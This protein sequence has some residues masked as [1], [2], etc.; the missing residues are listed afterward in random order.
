MTSAHITKR[1]VDAAKDRST[2][3]FIWD[4]KLAGFGLKVTPA[5]RK[6]YLFQYRMH[7][8]GTTRRVT[9]GQHGPWTPTRARDEAKRLAGL[10][11]SGTD[12]AA[13]H[14]RKK[15]DTLAD[16]FAQFMAEHVKTKLKPSTTY[17]YRLLADTH[18]LPSLG[19]RTF[20]ELQRSD[21]ARFHHGLSDKP[22]V[23][24]RTLAVLSKLFNWGEKHGLRPQGSNPCRHVEKYREGRRERFLSQAELGRLG[25]ALREA[26]THQTATPWTIA[27][28][29]LLA[30][31]GARL[32][33]ILTLQWAHVN[34]E[35]SCL[36][37]P[38]S[39]TGRKAV[40][41]NP[42]AVAVLQQ[43]PRLNGNPYVICGAKTGEHLVNLEKPWRRIR[44]AAG[45]NDV[46]LHDL[47][48]SFASVGAAMGGA[49]LVVI[50]KLLGHS[51]PSTTA[52]YAHL[53]DDPV[54][55]AGDAIGQ[56]IAAAMGIGGS[57]EVVAL[58]GATGGRKGE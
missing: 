52:R 13:E 55:A 36:L 45:L 8:R 38:D 20:G 6:V 25:D 29:R 23:G 5:G 50:G 30:L 22:Y 16:V 46:R 26:E 44:A 49:S 51:Q 10:V 14:A 9:I 24:N 53:A 28:I 1:T 41:L 3:L 47:R 31:T 17:Y 27:A 48:H 33:E 39:K 19:R 43:I 18:I 15:G 42:P 54:R 11:A 12:P 56:R 40:M 4:D 32:G 34:T 21:V 58:K 57:G 37:L 7:G 2:D 35:Q